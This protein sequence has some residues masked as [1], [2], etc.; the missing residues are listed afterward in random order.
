MF[1]SSG[2]ALGAEVTASA[3]RRS[4]LLVRSPKST[5]IEIAI[6]IGARTSTEVTGTSRHRQSIRVIWACCTVINACAQ[7]CSRRD[8]YMRGA[9]ALEIRQVAEPHIRRRAI[10]A[11]KERPSY[12]P[13]APEPF[14]TDTGRDAE[15]LQKGRTSYSDDQGRRGLR[16]GPAKV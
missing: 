16:Q 3:R 8:N 5:G 14:T 10:K 2:E 7:A 15:T 13:Q 1:T 12:S 4:T 6:V 11:S 9:S